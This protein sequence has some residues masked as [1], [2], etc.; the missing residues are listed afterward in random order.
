MCEYPLYTPIQHRCAHTH[1]HTHTHHTYTHTHTYQLPICN[2]VSFLIIISKL[3]NFKLLSVY[4]PSADQIH[5]AEDKCHSKFD[6]TH[7]WFIDNGQWPCPGSAFDLLN[8][9][10]GVSSYRKCIL[11]QLCQVFG[12][13]NGWKKKKKSNFLQLLFLFYFFIIWTIYL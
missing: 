1:T 6:K 7:G 13:I 9:L 3:Y 8:I 11:K 12:Q 4:L 2:F 5:L 10:Q